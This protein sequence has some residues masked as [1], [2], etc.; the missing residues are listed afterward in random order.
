MLQSG[1]LA[2]LRCPEDHSELAAASEAVVNRVNAAI[3]EGR[4]VNR[5]GQR[6]ERA[7]DAGLI[8]ADGN[9]LYPIVG[10]IPILLQD[11]AIALNQ[12]TNDR[13]G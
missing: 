8:R 5:A 13:R 4:L 6:V 1:V 3:R 9:W 2:I 7:I 12:L 11:D 10:Q